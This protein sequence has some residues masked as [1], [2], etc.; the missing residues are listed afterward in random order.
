[1]SVL[2]RILEKVVILGQA[3]GRYYVSSSKNGFKFLLLV[4]FPALD[5]FIGAGRPLMHLPF[6]ADC[7]CVFFVFFAVFFLLIVI[8][9]WLWL[10]IFLHFADCDCQF[11]C[12][13]WLC[14]MHLYT[15]LLGVF[16]WVGLPSP[17]KMIDQ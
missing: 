12:W 7:D 11:F 4:I 15:H 3:K 2:P 1:V 8:V 5:L 9:N 6:F 10:S 14:L 17:I 13:L 16:L